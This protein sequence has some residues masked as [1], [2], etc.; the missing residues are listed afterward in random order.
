VI[1]NY[2]A[3]LLIF[4]LVGQIFALTRRPCS[5]FVDMLRCHINC[6]IIIII[7]KYLVLVLPSLMLSAPL[8]HGENPGFVYVLCRVCPSSRD[9]LHDCHVN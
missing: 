2:L 8:S 3:L 4:H 1:V 7:I 5:D 9:G 6:C